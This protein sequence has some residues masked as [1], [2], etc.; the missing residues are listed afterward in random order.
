MREINFFREYRGQ[1]K[2]QNNTLVYV[3]IATIIIFVVYTYIGNVTKIKS[4]QDDITRMENELMDPAMQ[5]KVALSDEVN[6]KLS[7]LA[8]IEAGLVEVKSAVESRDIV[9]VK[10]LD[11]ISSTLPSEVSFKSLNIAAGSITIQAVSSN[12]QAIGEVQ[13]NLKEL[14]SISDVYIGGISEIGGLEGEY[15]FDLRCV[16]KGGN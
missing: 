8:Q 9:S 11:Q 4:L 6:E 5:E 16:L 15:S 13:H 3:L 7:L 2:E 12:R 10:L 1:E 14:D